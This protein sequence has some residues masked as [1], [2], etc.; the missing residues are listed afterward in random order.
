MNALREIY[1]NEPEK[2][3]LIDALAQVPTPATVEFVCGLA[4]SSQT[5]HERL[6]A[7]RA[8]VRSGEPTAEAALLRV[9]AAEQDA[10]VLAAAEQ[11]LQAV[12][13]K[14]AKP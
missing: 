6:L 11:G 13:R 9:L 7:V 12:R 5:S 8:L 2:N 4:M 14:G 10:A 3:V 1:A